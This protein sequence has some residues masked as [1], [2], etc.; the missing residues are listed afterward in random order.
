[1]GK[2]NGAICSQSYVNNSLP[3]QPAFS[4]NLTDWETRLLKRLYNL[5]NTDLKGDHLKLCYSCIVYLS[6]LGSDLKQI[7]HATL[8]YQIC[9]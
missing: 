9:F 1:M 7:Q 5:Q 2:V 6:F 8:N 4:M 3:I